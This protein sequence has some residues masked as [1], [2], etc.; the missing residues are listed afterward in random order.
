MNLTKLEID[1][2]PGLIELTAS[3]GWDY[4]TDELKTIMS[5]GIIYGHKNEDGKIISSAAIVEYDSKLAWIGIVSVNEEYRGLGLGR[6]VTQKCIESV[7][8]NVTSMLIATEEGKP[9]YEKMGFVTRDCIHKFLCDQYVFKGTVNVSNYS[10]MPMEKKDLTQV[11]KID[12]DAFGVDRK[13]LL[14]NRIAQS[15]DSLVV[16]NIDGEIIGYGLTV[17]GPVN[18]ILGPIVANNPET[19]TLILNHLIK[20]YEGKYRIDV[21]SGNEKFMSYLKERGFVQVS[22]PPIMINNSMQLPPRNNTYFGIVAQAF[23]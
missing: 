13:N 21:P 15:K 1:D 18:L 12:K 10:I 2:I 4:D 20:S 17:L 14:I 22:Q 9:M 8:N 7:S 16:K 19:A 6:I 11:L 3:M 5:S 23:G